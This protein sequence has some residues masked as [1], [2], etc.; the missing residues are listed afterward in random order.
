MITSVEVESESSRD[1]DHASYTGAL[2]TESSNLICMRKLTTLAF[3][4][5]AD[6]IGVGKF[7]MVNVT[8]LHTFR[9]WFL[10]HGLR[11][12]GTLYL[13]PLK[14][15]DDTKCRNWGPLGVVRVTQGHC[16]FQSA[17]EFLLAFHS[18]YVPIL[19][20]PFLAQFL[21]ICLVFATLDP[22]AKFDICCFIKTEDNR[23]VRKFK[24]RSRRPRSLMT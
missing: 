15:K 18:T 24:S 8:W 9:G 6:I 7:K 17:Y 14:L 23:W 10:I 1:P 11:S 5:S 19:P 21:F 2:S 3:S 12:I 20:L 22:A 13:C 4:R 16:H